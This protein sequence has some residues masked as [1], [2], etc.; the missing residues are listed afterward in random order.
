M[1][2]NL[3]DQGARLL[4]AEVAVLLKVVDKFFLVHEVPGDHGEHE[5]AVV[6][7]ILAFVQRIQQ[8]RHHFVFSERF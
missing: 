5:P 3:G 2:L 4:L 8:M 7:D 1:G 6:P